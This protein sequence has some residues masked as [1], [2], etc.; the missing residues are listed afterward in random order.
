M[1]TSALN[2]SS[3][4]NAEDLENVIRVR[5]LTKRFV[6]PRTPAE[7]VLALDNIDLDVRQRE[8]LTVIGP[9]GCGKTT[10]L[11]VIAGLVPFDSGSVT[12]NGKPVTGP[13]P[14]RAV[15]FQAFALLP[16]ATVIDNIAFGLR[17]R[18]VPERQRRSIARD[19]IRVVGL[20]GF[21]DRLPKE[22]S[23]GMQQ[24]VG[25][26]RAL[27]VDPEILLMDEPFG[28]LDEQTRRLL[29]EE[30]LRIWEEHRKTVIFVTHS[31]EEAVLL[32]DRILLLSPRP[33]RVKELIDVPLGRP[34]D[35]EA[36][37]DL[38]MIETRQHLWDQLR[39]MQV[40]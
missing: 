39:G 22:L 17:L 13:G 19:W 21:E 29:Q 33:G 25:L 36:E 1:T 24:R 27:A 3:S 28:S 32:G 18:G 6:G 7:G 4:P 37:H 26:A 5:G 15:V 9:S 40:L 23:G 14:D 30:L 11:R 38:G 16:W 31:M 12:V 10:L 34:R 8:F 20:E 2:D 35:R